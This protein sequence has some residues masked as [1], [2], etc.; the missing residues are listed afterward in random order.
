MGVCG[1]GS[2]YVASIT[3]G[4]YGRYVSVSPL[5]QTYRLIHKLQGLH[6]CEGNY[7]LRP[8][9]HSYFIPVYALYVT[10]L[11]NEL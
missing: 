6:T 5:L 11:V 9:V 8:I 10:N 2:N 1:Q 7:L 4:F 3:T